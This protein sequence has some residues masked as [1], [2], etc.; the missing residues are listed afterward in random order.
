MLTNKI[1]VSMN[2]ILM[3]RGW[4]HEPMN[5]EMGRRGLE[6]YSFRD[7]MDCMFVSLPLQIYMLKP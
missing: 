1:N 3:N 2:Q 4:S 7:V 6:F 5:P